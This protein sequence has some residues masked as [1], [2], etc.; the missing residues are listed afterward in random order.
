MSP[1]VY[2]EDIGRHEGETVTLKGW[3]YNKR[4]SGKLHFLQVRDGTGIVQC[5]VFKNDVPAEQFALADHLPQESSLIVTGVGAQGRPRAARLRARRQRSRRSCTRRRSTRSRRRSTASRSCST[6]ATSGCARRASTRSCAC[7]PRSIRACRDYFDSAR[8]RR[9]ST[10]RSSRRACEGTTTLFETRYFD[11]KAYLT[12]SGQLY[13]E[14]GAMALRQGLLLRADLPRRE[15]E[16]APPPHRVLDGR[17]RGR[18]HGPRR[19]HGPRRGLPR[20]R[21]AARARERAAASSR[22]SSATS[23]PLETRAEA[24]PAHHLRRGDRAAAARRA[25]RSSGATT[26]AA[27]RRPRSRSSSTGRCSSTA[28]RSSSRRST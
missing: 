28:I 20:L 2:I 3:L 17:A 6:T 21:R 16:D 12:Q 27:T 26:S 15:V 8:L 10:R 4:S 25:S 11:E 1:W 19:R 13:V 5:V 24:V 18:V 14:A 9:S 23:A 22:R 7:A